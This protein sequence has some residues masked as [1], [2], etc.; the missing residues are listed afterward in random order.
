M[1]PGALAVA[2]GSTIARALRAPDTKSR[3]RR[4]QTAGVLAVVFVASFAAYLALIGDAWTTRETV[5]A[6][7]G[8]AAMIGAIG[9]L[10]A[11]LLTPKSPKPPQ[12]NRAI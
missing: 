10:A 3:R 8:N 6:I 2:Q 7:G 4:L 5:I 9:F 12:H 1:P 11:G